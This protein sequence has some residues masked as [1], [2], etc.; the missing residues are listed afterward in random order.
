MAKNGDKIYFGKCVNDCVDMVWVAGVV[1]DDRSDA[2][3]RIKANIDDEEME[4]ITLSVTSET[5]VSKFVELDEDEQEYFKDTDFF[6][7][8]PDSLD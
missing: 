8:D 6:L 3:E 2:I 4:L 5:M 7:Y 1:A